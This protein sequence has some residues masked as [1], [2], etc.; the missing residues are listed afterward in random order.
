[1]TEREQVRRWEIWLLA[2]LFLGIF[3]CQLHTWAVMS[4]HRCDVEMTWDV[5]ELHSRWIIENSEGL[6][7]LG[8]SRSWVELQDSLN[9]FLNKWELR[10]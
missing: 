10:E 7:V 4:R 3:F 9:S 2:V 8:L 1:M 6:E 5:L